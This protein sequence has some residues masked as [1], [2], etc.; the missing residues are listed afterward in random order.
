[1]L[2]IRKICVL[3]VETGIR[4]IDAVSPLWRGNGYSSLSLEKRYFHLQAE[5]GYRNYPL[6]W[7]CEWGGGNLWVD[8]AYRTLMN[9]LYQP[10]DLCIGCLCV[11]LLFL[12]AGHFWVLSM[13]GIRKSCS[14]KFYLRLEA[15]AFALT[16]M[17][18]LPGQF[19]MDI[20]SAILD[21]TGYMAHLN[22]G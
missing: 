17:E 1:M 19:P 6:W 3:R 10:S 13:H 15:Q 2:I 21:V 5:S 22:N 16:N 7:T 20:S 14:G 11:R 8:P 12:A 4:V 9:V 18:E